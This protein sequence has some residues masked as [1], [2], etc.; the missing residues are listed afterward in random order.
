MDSEYL[1][2]KLLEQKG[3]IKIT[4]VLSKSHNNT[5]LGVIRW[6]GAWRQYVYYPESFTLYSKGCMEDIIT[7]IEKLNEDRRLARQIKLLNQG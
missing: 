6:H 4:E 3:K 5:R 2:F 7:Y 1:K